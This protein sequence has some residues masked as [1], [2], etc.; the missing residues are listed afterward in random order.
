MKHRE[1]ELLLSLERR[2][3]KC[4][5]IKLAVKYENII[6]FKWPKLIILADWRLKLVPMTG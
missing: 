1:S 4:Q 3:F 5:L 6:I 2:G